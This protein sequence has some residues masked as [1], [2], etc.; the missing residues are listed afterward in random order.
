MNKQKL[1]EMRLK[2]VRVRPIARRFDET[3]GIELEPIDDAWIIVNA[4]CEEVELRNPRSSQHVLLGMDHVKEYMGDPGRS[5]G[6]L[7]LKSQIS[8]FGRQV[9][10]IEPLF[11]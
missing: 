7:I 5:D 2:R 11:R 4:S 3:R 8:L 6:M 9:P 1:S 10:Q